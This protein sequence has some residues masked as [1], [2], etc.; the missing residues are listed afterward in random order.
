MHWLFK[1]S[2]HLSIKKKFQFALP[3]TFCRLSLSR[4]RDDKNSSVE[5]GQLGNMPVRIQLSDHTR[6][7]ILPSLSAKRQFPC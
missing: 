5:T 3:D 6:D 2:L 1:K 4:N 7:A